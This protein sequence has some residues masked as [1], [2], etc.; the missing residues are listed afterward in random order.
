MD[1]TMDVTAA[2]EQRL[3]I[4][5]PSKDLI[6]RFLDDTPLRLTPGVE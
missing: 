1:G 2:L 6:R 5:E 4:L 3:K